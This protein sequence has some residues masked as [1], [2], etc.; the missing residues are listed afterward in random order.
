[1]DMSDLKRALGRLIV[2]LRNEHRLSQE[3]LALEAH[4]D[5][6]RVGEIERGEAN[7]T[8]D[9]LDRI[10]KVLGQSLGLLIVQAEELASGATSR[11]AATVNTA[12]LDTSVPLP[13]GLTHEQLEIAFNR[14]LAMLDQIG[15]NPDAGDIQANIYSGAVSNIVTKAIAEA[16]SF[17]QNKHT[18]HPDLYNPTLDR[19]D[20]DWGLEMKA[21][22][23]VGKGGESH[24]PG[25]VW[26]MVVVY[27]VIDGQTQFIQAEVAALTSEDWTVH[28]R[29][30]ES[31]R[32]R[33]AVTKAAATRRLRENSV[34]LDPNHVPPYLKQIKEAGQQPYLV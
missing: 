18:A 15:L 32:T 25:R 14:A 11:P 26:F 3:D 19:T 17:V 28:E 6:T 4:V 12:F 5:R 7:P 16:S 33:T 10:A 8:I 31:R 23:Q 1:M 13:R 27:K 30:A 21:T 9:T 22:H 2:K 24:N 29:G 20:P 34:Y